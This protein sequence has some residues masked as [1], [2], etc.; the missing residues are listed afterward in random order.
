MGYFKYRQKDILKT[1]FELEKTW[2]FR[3]SKGHYM[4]YFTHGIVFHR[5]FCE[6]FF[7]K[8]KKNWKFWKFPKNQK[9]HPKYPRGEVFVI[10]FLRN[11]SK[12]SRLPEIQPIMYFLLS[13]FSW[14]FLFFR[15]A[16]R[17][18]FSLYISSVC[19]K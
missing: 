1:W 19:L 11:L 18:T 8:Y 13:N 9:I 5:I 15:F 3:K 12:K 2:K 6:H 7:L 4:P 14:I 17:Q 16:T 10:S